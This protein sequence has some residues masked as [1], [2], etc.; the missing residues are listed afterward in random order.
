MGIHISILPTR[1][2]HASIQAPGDPIAPR[3][4]RQRRIWR[5]TPRDAVTDTPRI[6]AGADA[7]REGQ[8]G[9][10]GE[11]LHFHLPSF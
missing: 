9:D 3:P 1:P 10:D 11:V 4:G 2:G 6:A 7:G 8:D 5:L